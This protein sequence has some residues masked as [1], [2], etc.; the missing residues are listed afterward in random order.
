MSDQAPQ[1]PAISTRII[2]ALLRGLGLSAPVSEHLWHAVVLVVA[3]LGMVALLRV[4][5]GL[6][7]AEAG[8]NLLLVLAG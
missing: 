7:I 5:L 2:V 1:H 3:G 6:V 8:A 4:L